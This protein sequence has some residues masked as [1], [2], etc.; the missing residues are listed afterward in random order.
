MNKFKSVLTKLE[1][2]DIVQLFDFEGAV[3]ERLQP[4]EIETLREAL[5]LASIVVG[6]CNV[7]GDVSP[8]SIDGK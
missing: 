8:D 4:H 2:V 7:K 6:A 5:L 1:Y 3:N